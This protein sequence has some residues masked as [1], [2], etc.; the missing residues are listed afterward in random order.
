VHV[1][2]QTSLKYNIELLICMQS[3]NKHL[4]YTA[5]KRFFILL[6]PKTFLFPRF[7]FVVL[8]KTFTLFQNGYADGI[9]DGRDSTYQLG[10]DRG[11]ENGFRNSFLLGQQ[12]GRINAVSDSFPQAAKAS[13]SDSTLANPRRGHCLICVDQTKLNHSIDIIEKSQEQHFVVTKEALRER[14]KEINKLFKDD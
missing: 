12:Q 6:N 7:T 4:Y 11:F 3:I 5:I 10:F 9:S 14:Y 13:E 1:G 2:D 8:T